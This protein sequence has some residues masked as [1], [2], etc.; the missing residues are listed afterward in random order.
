MKLLRFAD[1]FRARAGK[2]KGVYDLFY[3]TNT[4]LH[5]SS[6]KSRSPCRRSKFYQRRFKQNTAWLRE[7]SNE[8]S[9]TFNFRIDTT[10][11][12]LLAFSRDSNNIRAG[13]GSPANAVLGIY[14]YFHCCL[15]STTTSAYPD[16]C[17]IPNVVGCGTLTNPVEETFHTNGLVNHSDK[18]PGSAV[19]LDTGSTPLVYTSKTT[20]KKGRNFVIPGL[21]SVEQ[22]IQTLDILASITNPSWKPAQCS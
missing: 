22:G 7:L 8:D 3:I 17:T 16:R 18:F 15:Q 9:R 20:D 19:A 10:I 12:R 6:N 1:Q 11:G 2:Y 13:A 14:S 21:Y 4:V 5:C